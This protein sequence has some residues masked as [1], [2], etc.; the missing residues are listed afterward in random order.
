MQRRRP[1]FILLLVLSLTATGLPNTARAAGPD[2]SAC[3]SNPFGPG[4]TA[5]LPSVLKRR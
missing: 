5:G 3:L 4:C 1:I 2:R